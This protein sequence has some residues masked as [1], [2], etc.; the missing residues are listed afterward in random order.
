MEKCQYLGCYKPQTINKLCCYHDA[1]RQERNEK[2]CVARRTKL[3]A[4]QIE[5]DTLLCK[6]NAL[7]TKHEQLKKKYVLHT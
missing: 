5:Y 2:R 6:Y 3:K 4:L 1:V 7:C